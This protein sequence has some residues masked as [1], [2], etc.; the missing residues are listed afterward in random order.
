MRLATAFLVG[1]VVV[2]T[3]VIVAGSTG[4]GIGPGD[5]V[6]IRGAPARPLLILAEGTHLLTLEPPS[7][8]NPASQRR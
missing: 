2:T 1:M 3:G 4:L 7:R 6:V 5:I 8:M